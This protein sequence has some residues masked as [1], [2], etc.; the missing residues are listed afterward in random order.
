M[1]PGQERALCAATPRGRPCAVDF[2]SAAQASP[3][4]RP[5]AP[6]VELAGR[7]HVDATAAMP[8]RLGEPRGVQLVMLG[9]GAEV[10]QHRVALAGEQG[11]SARSC[12]VP[13][14]RCACSRRS[15]C[16][17][18]RRRPG[19]IRAATRAPSRGARSAACRSRSAA[20]S[21]RS[22]SRRARRCSWSRSS[23]VVRQLAPV[24]FEVSV[25]ARMFINRGPCSPLTNTHSVDSG[26]YPISLFGARGAHHTERQGH[27]SLRCQSSCLDPG[28]Q[29]H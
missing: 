22:S 8:A 9:G 2:G 5:L 15:G 16:C 24:V 6:R 12:R 21:R 28:A 18:R 29:S 17:S 7:R 23:L 19:W 11:R 13:I 27:F 14:R 20:P 10:P 1:G 26:S 25:R 3:A 4:V